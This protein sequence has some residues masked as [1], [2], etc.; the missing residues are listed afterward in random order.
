MKH[1][2]HARDCET[3]VPP[4]MLM[5]RKHWAMVP[6]ETQRA[7]YRSYRKGQCVD[8]NPSRDWLRA[9]RE[10]INAVALQEGKLTQ[11]QADRALD[12]I[13]AE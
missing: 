1:T 5:C 8:K 7:V 3:A 13:G 4:E 2:C 10:A 12:W 11:E 9:A 6:L